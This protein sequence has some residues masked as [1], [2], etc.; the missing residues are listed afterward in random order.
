MKVLCELLISKKKLFFKLNIKLRSVILGV[1]MTF[2][3]GISKAKSDITE[4]EVRSYWIFWSME[5]KITD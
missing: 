2:M 1:F 5:C 3:A 4:S